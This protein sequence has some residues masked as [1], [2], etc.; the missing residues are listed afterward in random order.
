MDL[1]YF[2]T[3]CKEVLSRKGE[4]LKSGRIMGYIAV[5]NVRQYSDDIVTI[6]S[7]T[8]NGSELLEV[9]VRYMVD[10]KQIENPCIMVKDDDMFRYHGDWRHAA[11]HIETL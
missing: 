7:A 4:D 9:T 8:H 3:K 1:Q 10:G 6:A 5:S 2:L 11:P